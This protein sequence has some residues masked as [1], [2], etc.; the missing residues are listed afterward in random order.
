MDT[1]P[2]HKFDAGVQRSV[3]EGECCNEQAKKTIRSG[4]INL[5]ISESILVI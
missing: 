2:Y 5:L 4:E 3:K 1:C